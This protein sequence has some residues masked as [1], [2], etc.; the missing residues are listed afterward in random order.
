[1]STYI[2]NETFDESDELVQY[3]LSSFYFSAFILICILLINSVE[4]ADKKK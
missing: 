1:M 4:N 3:D 2:E